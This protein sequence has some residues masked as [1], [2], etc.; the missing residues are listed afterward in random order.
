M[1]P[2]RQPVG[3]VVPVEVM[4]LVHRSNSVPVV[5]VEAR[6]DSAVVPVVA[7]PAA[8]PV[9]VVP[10]AVVPVVVAVA[11]PAAAQRVLLAAVVRKVGR[12]NRSGRSAKNSR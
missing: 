1:D 6:A 8:V 3:P 4:A 7:R 12:E 2:A 9:A 11:A 10:V 5:P